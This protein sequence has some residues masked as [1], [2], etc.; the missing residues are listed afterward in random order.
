MKKIKNAC[1]RVT[2]FVEY[3]IYELATPQSEKGCVRCHRNCDNGY[4]VLEGHRLRLC[5]QKCYREMYDQYEK[6]QEAIGEGGK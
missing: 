1:H 5:S 6:Y 2:N 4:F 3:C